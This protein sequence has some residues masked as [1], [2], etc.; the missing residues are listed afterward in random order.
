M[1]KFFGLYINEMIKIISKVNVIVMIVVMVVITASLVVVNKIAYDSIPD[2]SYYEVG[3]ENFIIDDMKNQITEMES[4]LKGVQD[5]I[6]KSDEDNKLALLV[7]ENSLKNIIEMYK[8]FSE[9]GVN[10][11]ANTWDVSLYNQILSNKN[12][13][14]QKNIEN[15][16]G[17]LSNEEKKELVILQE[18]INKLN[19]MISKGDYIGYINFSDENIKKDTMLKEEKKKIYLES[20]EI[21]RK[22]NPNGDT[23][24]E[25][26]NLE[27]VLSE[28]EN[29]KIILL[30][31]VDTYNNKPLTPERRDEIQNKIDV[32]NYK[33]NNNIDFNIDYKDQ[34]SSSV[35]SSF[36]EFGIFFLS[37]ILIIVAGSTISNEISTG[38]IKSLIISPMKRSKIYSAKVLSIV[39]F[40][41]ACLIILYITLMFAIKVFWGDLTMN[42]FTTVL[43]G[44]VVEINF[45][46][47]QFILLTIKYSSVLFFAIFALMLSTITRNTAI[48]VSISIASL[49]AGAVVTQALNFLDS[50][51]WVKFLPYANLNL[52]TK[53]LPN[54]DIFNIINF[55][56]PVSVSLEFSLIY[57]IITFVCISY[58]GYDSFV[59]RD[60]K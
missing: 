31:N 1:R 14:F 7:E 42:P 34:I 30:E 24:D 4:R 18:N 49:F 38:S 33:I 45:Y 58:I 19:E 21:R 52:E 60:I 47:Y 32:T 15:T 56:K 51:D 36:M 13:V 25:G 40:G 2:E 44:K 22:S 39:T 50:S 16:M 27:K 43:S 8:T 11:Y 48:S 41:I 3:G 53:I 10:I 6:S 46:L 17:L 26:Q 55:T 54:Y 35:T 20:N 9:K 5:K 12:I 57:L 23:G 28:F 59:R 37:V 29:L